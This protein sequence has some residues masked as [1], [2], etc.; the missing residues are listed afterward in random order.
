[1][2]KIIK[3]C[4]NFLKGYKKL[5]VKMI[6]G[7]YAI[8]VNQ[9]D[10]FVGIVAS[11]LVPNKKEFWGKSDDATIKVKCVSHASYKHSLIV[12]K[13]AQHNNYCWGI[14]IDSNVS[15]INNI[16]I[17]DNCTTSVNNTCIAANMTG[18]KNIPLVKILN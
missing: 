16:V 11:A 5:K 13:V 8:I 10:E 15:N 12:K 14:E 7:N 9:K 3:N 18:Y 4:F 6:V 1:M 17:I 2:K